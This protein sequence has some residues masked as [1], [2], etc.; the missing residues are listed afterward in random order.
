MNLDL[1]VMDT[2][3]TVISVVD[4]YESLIWTDRYRECGD[5]EIYTAATLQNIALF[6]QDRY[7]WLRDSNHLMIIESI[8]VDS[9]AEEGSHLIVTGRSLESIL[10]RRIVWNQTILTGNLQNGVKKLLTDAIIN[11]T[12]S[13]RAIENFIFVESD[14]E[15]ITDL[16]IEAQYT[17]DTLYDILTNLCE[18]TQTGFSIVLN[19]DLQ[20]EMTLYKGTDRSY[21]QSLN[22]YVVFS[23]NFENI[24]NSN[25]LSSYQTLKN[26]TLVA[27]EGEG[28]DRRTLSV[29]SAS[30]L[31]RRELFTDARDISSTTDDGTLTPTQYNAQLEQR[32][33]E[34]LSENKE[35]KS[36][37]GK[38][39]SSQMFVYGRD[40]FLGDIVQ[41]ANEYGI[42]GEARVTEIIYSQSKTGIEIYPTFEAIQNDEQEGGNE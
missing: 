25:Y 42:E 33:K 36:F 1:L 5:F 37:E 30:G 13:D 9:N 4:T 29:G 16:T 15:R 39:E 17:G 32:G 20:F 6:K 3:F 10:D 14:D 35:T 7:L 8:E 21:A 27:G 24:I 22:P 38:V 31:T 28:S 34:K 23:P 18:D 19:D 26:V 41:I 12:N 40:F 2:D 11:P